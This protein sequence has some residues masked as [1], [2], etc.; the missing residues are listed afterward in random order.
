[1]QAQFRYDIENEANKKI[2]NLIF[3]SQFIDIKKEEELAMIVR[4]ILPTN[5][6]NTLLSN[7]V[8]SQIKKH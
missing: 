4:M 1:M 7:T 6:K 2:E 8:S 3:K 5:L